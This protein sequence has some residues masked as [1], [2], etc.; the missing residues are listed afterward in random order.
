MKKNVQNWKKSDKLCYVTKG[1][2]DVLKKIASD[3]HSYVSVTG[4]PGSGKSTA[5]RHAALYLM[6]TFGY[7]IYLINHPEEFKKYFDEERKQVFL[8]DDVIGEYF[9]DRN[10]LNAWDRDNEGIRNCLEDS[11]NVKFLSSLRVQLYKDE[12]LRVNTYIFNDTNH[13]TDLGDIKFRLDSLEMKNMLRHYLKVKQVENVDG[14][15]ESIWWR[16]DSTGTQFASFFPLLC[17]V[18]AE[19]ESVREHPEKFFTDPF[20]ALKDTVQNI[21]FQNKHQFCGLMLCTIMDLKDHHFSQLYK[22][23]VTEKEVRDII[24]KSNELDP[25]KDLKKILNELKSIDGVYISYIGNSFVFSHSIFQNIVT[26]LNEDAF[27]V[28]KYGRVDFIQSRVRINSKLP[29]D[30]EYVLVFSGKEKIEA[31]ADRMV[32]EL[33]RNLWRGAWFISEYHFNGDDYLISCL[34]SK[35]LE[36]NDSCITNTIITELFSRCLERMWIYSKAHNGGKDEMSWPCYK[37]LTMLVEKADVNKH[38]MAGVYAIFASTETG[39]LQ[40]IKLL[41]QH[42]ADINILD[43]DQQSVLH[44]AM[45]LKNNIEITRYLLSLE[46]LTCLNQIDSKNRRPYWYVMN[47]CVPNQDELINMYGERG[48]I[49]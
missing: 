26:Y 38:V 48:A 20:F 29:E 37:L 22:M 47:T 17:K 19:H 1:I 12:A 10:K 41:V 7:T 36:N 4:V 35:L 13:C 31:L 42:Q 49:M 43:R 44:R 24:I 16:T 27:F 46:T 18:F 9:V 15:I 3:D 30:D 14:L 40:L 5:I 11:K 39:S 33:K 34:K 23:D 28:F 45:K 32:I 21:K 2:N 8:I 6:D 25:E